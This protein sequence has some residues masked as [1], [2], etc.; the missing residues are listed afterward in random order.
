MKKHCLFASIAI[1]AV[2]LTG[3]SYGEDDFAKD[4]PRRHE[5][6]QREKNQQERIAQG[7][8]SGSLSP[9]ETAHLEKEEA[10]LKHQEHQNV[11][12]NGG[13]PAILNFVLEMK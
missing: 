5:V 3:I 12:N 6:T 8:K 2:A 1:A 9:K 11:K 4:H 13:Y 10:R 7:I